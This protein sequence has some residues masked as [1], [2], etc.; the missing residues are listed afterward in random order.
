MKVVL[1]TNVLVSAVLVATSPPARILQAWRAGVF[2]LVVSGDLLL[3]LRDVLN[4][5]RIAERSGWSAEDVATLIGALMASA[6]FVEPGDVLHVVSD[7]DDNRVL[8]AAL[9]GE[10]DYIVSGD[11]A[12]LSLGR[13]EGIEIVTPARLW[14]IL[15]S[16][17]P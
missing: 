7:D 17:E 11:R 14:A 5:P 9:A 15:S 1:D 8:E 16:Q 12:L 3:E 2:Q 6:A 10:A 13:Y 4:R